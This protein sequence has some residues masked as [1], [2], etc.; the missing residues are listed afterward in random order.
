MNLRRYTQKSIGVISGGIKKL[1][2]M[3]FPTVLKSQI[4]LIYDGAEKSQ[5]G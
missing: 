5:R 3:N 2:Q 4:S 1:V